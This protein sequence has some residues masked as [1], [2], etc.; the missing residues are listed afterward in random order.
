MKINSLKISIF[1]SLNQ[2]LGN[3][4]W[5]LIRKQQPVT[6]KASDFV[7]DQDSKR[8]L[9]ADNPRLTSLIQR[10][11][12]MDEVLTNSNVWRWTDTQVS[13]SLLQN[14]RGDRAYVWQLK[15]VDLPEVKY[16]LSAYYAMTNDRMGL[17]NSLSDDN[18][19]SNNLFSVAGRP[20]SRDLL[21]SINEINFLERHLSLSA[22]KHLKVL[23]IGAGY[24]RLAHRFSQAHKNLEHYYCTD[25]IPFSVFLCEFYLRYRK[26]TNAGVVE[27]PDVSESLRGK[28]IQLACNIHSF[29]ECSLS[30]I[31]WWVNT[32]SLLEIKYFFIIPNAFEDQGNRLLTNAREDFMP[33]LEKH[34]YRLLVKEAKYG[35][36]GVQ[37]Y[38]LYPTYYYLFEKQ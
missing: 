1:N 30:A 38:G 14:F 25:A 9:R 16:L 2:V 10:Y 15:G 17:M 11:L 36:H 22:V 19:F 29:S 4:G 31:D 26:V 24:G 27:M 23:D 33:I 12:T 8:Y 34:G 3:L 32:V 18:A 13:E 28:G 37:K 6:S 7:M 20:V 21:D 35:D 5:S